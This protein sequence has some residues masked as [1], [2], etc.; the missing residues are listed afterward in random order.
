MGTATQQ[1]EHRF[2]IRVRGAHLLLSDWRWPVTE[3]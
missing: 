1:G 3:H 2:L